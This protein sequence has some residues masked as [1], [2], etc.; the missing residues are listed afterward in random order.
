M[1][2]AN[3]QIDHELDPEQRE[4]VRQ[5]GCWPIEKAEEEGNASC[6]RKK[7]FVKRKQYPKHVAASYKY[8]TN[9]CYF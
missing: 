5:T 9:V 1:E 7:S 3:G 2:K 6:H 8:Y 4:P